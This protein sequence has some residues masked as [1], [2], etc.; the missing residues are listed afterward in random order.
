MNM[1]ITKNL[2]SGLVPADVESIDDS[3]RDVTSKTHAQSLAQMHN[4]SLS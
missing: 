4:P 2:L 3:S 1:G